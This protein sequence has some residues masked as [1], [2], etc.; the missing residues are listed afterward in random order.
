MGEGL[1]MSMHAH[2]HPPQGKS[3]GGGDSAMGG[4]ENADGTGQGL[5]QSWAW[6]QGRGPLCPSLLLHP[7]SLSGASSPCEFT[8]H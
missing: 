3:V 5:E 2:T 4:G 7:E 8:A 6:D 1:S